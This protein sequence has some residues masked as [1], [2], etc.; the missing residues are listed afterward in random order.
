MRL[1]TVLLALAM[2]LLLPERDGLFVARPS[3]V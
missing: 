2:G 3:K 1:R